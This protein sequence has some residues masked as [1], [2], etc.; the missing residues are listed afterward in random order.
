M[1]VAAAAMLLGG[2][3]A[4]TRGGAGEPVAR[5][6]HPILAWP[7]GPFEVRVSFD[8]PLDP[9]V[10]KSVVGRLIPFEEA[11]S[12]VAQAKARSKQPRPSRVAP[13]L[14]KRGALRVAAA[15]LDDDARTLVLVT[16]PHPRVATY[17]LHLTGIRSAG[18]PEPGE[19]IDLLYGLGGVGVAWLGNRSEKAPSWSGC[20]P[21]LDPGIVR[22]LT[23]GSLA[24]E[25][26]LALMGQPGRLTLDTLFV[27]PSGPHTL[28]LVS[29]VPF[30]AFIGGVKVSSVND[31]EGPQKIEH[32]VDATGEPVDLLVT[33]PT[34]V[35]GKPTTFK[36]SYFKPDNPRDVRL[37]HERLLLPW[38][39]TV[40]PP[41]VEPPHLPQDLAGGDPERGKTVFFGNQGRCSA[42]HT[43]GGKGANVGPE[44]GHQFERPPAEVYRDIAEP[45]LWINPDYVAYTVA[46]KDGRVLV[47]I[48]RAEG[49][50]RVRVTDTDARTTVVRRSE[51]EEF[52][53]SSTSIMPVGVAGVLGPGSMR[54]LLA[55]LT[56][57][58]AGAR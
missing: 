31:P 46:L 13:A 53:P 55:F 49:A 30:Q 9:A 14:A 16:D 26:A 42:C 58:L 27:L 2:V 47:G 44:L 36:A 15:R 48:V 54:D 4:R 3:L 8:Q 51:I 43:I 32:R 50:D 37:A 1:L 24:H 6:P 52:R 57:P 38:A 19:S 5:P 11:I 35:G 21:D 12:V 33:L 29:N 22:Q 40:P 7:A 25:R 18:Q 23:V 17:S 10:T 41:P 34:G 56:D 20:W 39:T 45:G 28:R